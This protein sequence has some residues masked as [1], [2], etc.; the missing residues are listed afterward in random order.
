[1]YRGPGDSLVIELYD[2][3][4]QSESSFGNDVAFL[5][6]VTAEHKPR[7]L[8]LL[9]AP[10]EAPTAGDDAKLY[11]LLRERFRDYYEVQR[12]LDANSIPY[13]KNFDSWA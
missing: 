9:R 11:M 5:I 4:P 13:R 2:H 6:H 8:A 12:W 7:V 10:G 1:M 3:G